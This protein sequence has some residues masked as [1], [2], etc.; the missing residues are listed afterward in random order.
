MSYVKK[1]AIPKEP[2]DPRRARFDSALKENIEIINGLRG[3]KLTLLD[4]NASLS[5]VIAKIN[6]VIYLIQK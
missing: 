3:N 4:A 6:E 2:T 5:D 1:P